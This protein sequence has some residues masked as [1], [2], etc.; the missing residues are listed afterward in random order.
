[1]QQNTKFIQLGSFLK[2]IKMLFTIKRISTPNI[3][4]KVQIL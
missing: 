4:G 1:M 2:V 3:V